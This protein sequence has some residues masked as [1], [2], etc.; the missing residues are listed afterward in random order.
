MLVGAFYGTV[1]GGAVGMLVGSF[2]KS[3]QWTEIPL[4][5]VS[6]RLESGRIELTLR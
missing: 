3:D 6:A 4:G 2:I 5:P 1:I